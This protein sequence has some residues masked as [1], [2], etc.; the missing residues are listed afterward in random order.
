MWKKEIFDI[1]ILFFFSECA[2]GY[3]ARSYPKLRGTN[4]QIV[5][6]SNAKI[7]KLKSSLLYMNVPENFIDTLKLFLWYSNEQINKK[8]D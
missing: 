4:T 6:Q 7:R 2:A 1:Q 5:E 3:E 8:Y